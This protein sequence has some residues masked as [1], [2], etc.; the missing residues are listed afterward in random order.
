[1]VRSANEEN[2]FPIIK[3]YYFSIVFININYVFFE[4][5]LMGKLIHL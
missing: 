5:S 3:T 2:L 1:M 4:I